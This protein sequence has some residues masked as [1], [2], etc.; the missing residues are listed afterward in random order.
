MT[1][2]IGQIT[3]FGGTFAPTGWAFCDGQLLAVSGN[4]ALFSLLGTIYG[5]DGRTT[6]GLPDLRGRVA[7]H[8][9]SGPGLSNINLGARGGHEFIT[10]NTNNLPNHNHPVSMSLHFRNE[11]G[12]ETNPGSGSFAIAPAQI[13]HAD[14]PTS[15]STFHSGTITAPNT[16]SSGGGSSYNNHQPFQVINYII[17]L[18]GEYPSRT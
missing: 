11:V 9:G 5:G 3:M 6:F 16:G 7:L 10:L 4:D 18:T 14:G 12:D 13:Y 8:K 1:P 2:F 17:A 15:S